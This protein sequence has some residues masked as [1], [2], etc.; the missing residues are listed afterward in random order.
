MPCP[1]IGTVSTRLLKPVQGD[2]LVGVDRRR[3]PARPVGAEVVG[4]ETRGGGAVAAVDGL[5]ERLAEAAEGG[6]GGGRG[7]TLRRERE[8][9]GGEQEEGSHWTWGW[10]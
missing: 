7:G 3:P 5:H 6:V 1:P 2:E 9:R 4:H 10:G 8:G